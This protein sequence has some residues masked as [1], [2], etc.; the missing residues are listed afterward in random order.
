MESITFQLGTKLEQTALCTSNGHSLRIVFLKQLLH[1]K[2]REVWVKVCGTVMSYEKMLYS[3]EKL[4]F[5]DEFTYLVFLD[6][7][8]E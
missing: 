7:L 5:T 2:N 6:V 1:L 4:N 8:N 3:C